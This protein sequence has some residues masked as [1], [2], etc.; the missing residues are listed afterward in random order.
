LRKDAVR[1]FLRASIKR[2]A[3]LKAFA[4]AVGRED[5]QVSLPKPLGRRAQGRQPMTHDAVSHQDVL[6]LNSTAAAVAQQETGNV[7]D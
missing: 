4:H 1:R 6:T 2:N 7:A 3:A 5:Q